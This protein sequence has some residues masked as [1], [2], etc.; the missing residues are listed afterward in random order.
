MKQFRTIELDST[1]LKLN[2]QRISR[3]EKLVA[4]TDRTP[5]LFPPWSAILKAPSK[6][7]NMAKH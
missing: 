3:I 7:F 4:N 6:L 2:I 1:R 5:N